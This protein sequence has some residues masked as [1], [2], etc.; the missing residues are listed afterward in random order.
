M[1]RGEIALPDGS[2]L[3]YRW[4]AVCLALFVSYS[5]YRQSRFSF[6]SRT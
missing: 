5:W 3:P 4:F 6:N 2:T 1:V